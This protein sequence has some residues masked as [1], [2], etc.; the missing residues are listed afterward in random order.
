MTIL[1]VRH[2]GIEISETCTGPTGTFENLHFADAGSGFVWRSL[3]WIGPKQG[4]VDIE[5]VL[6]YTG[7]SSADPATR[8]AHVAPASAVARIGRIV[9][10]RNE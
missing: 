7:V 5:I 4:L 8:L 6:P 9:R 1:E 2:R 3:Q 10:A